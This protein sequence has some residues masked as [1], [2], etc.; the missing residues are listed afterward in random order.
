MFPSSSELMVIVVFI[1]ILFGG[2]KIPEIARFIG[3]GVHELKKAQRD[4]K[5]EID[6]DSFDKKDTKDNDLKG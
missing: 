4:F 6:L 3:K 2:K 5:K 1:L